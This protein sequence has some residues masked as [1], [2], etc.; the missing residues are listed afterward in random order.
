MSIDTITDDLY[1]IILHEAIEKNNLFI[2]IVNFTNIILINKQ[3][4]NILKNLY[5]KIIQKKI[6]FF[7]SFNIN[8]DIIQI[9]GGYFNM[10]KIPYFNFN[11]NFIGPTQYI[12]NICSYH[13]K[14]PIMFSV[15]KY[16]R[17]LFTFKFIIKHLDNHMLESKSVTT[18]F[19]R[20]TSGNTWVYG[21]FY[22][23]SINDTPYFKTDDVKIFKSI[24]D[25][26]TIEKEYL[27]FNLDI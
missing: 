15:D 2:D 7:K 6:Y 26:K 25:R 21:N 27:F 8:N 18:L 20:Y 17:L 19:Q 22:K 13:L 11:N 16:N 3:I 4:F 24:I 5:K 9:F 12:D 1:Y 10:T 14:T 23:E